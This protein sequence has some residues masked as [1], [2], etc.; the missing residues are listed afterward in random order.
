MK[1]SGPEPESVGLISA[2]RTCYSRWPLHVRLQRHIDP[3]NYLQTESGRLFTEER[4]RVA[5]EQAYADLE[6]ALRSAGPNCRLYVVVG[7]QGAG[8]TSWIQRSAESCGVESVFLDAALPARRHRCRALALAAQCG[9]PAIAVWVN[10]P[11][12]I[13]LARNKRRPPDERVLEAAVRSVFSLLEPPALEE[14]FAQVLEVGADGRT[15]RTDR[16]ISD[17]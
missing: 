15:I 16:Q 14:G 5:W 2:R 6:S 9:V 13:A 10:T 8:K 1:T 11:L 17:G 7:L 3:D 12:E 4:N